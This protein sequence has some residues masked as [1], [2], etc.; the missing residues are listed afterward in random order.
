MRT[1]G[2]DILMDIDLLVAEEQQEA[3]IEILVRNGWAADKLDRF[4]GFRHH[5]PPLR[6]PSSV[7][8]EIHHGLGTG[9]CERVLPAREAIE[10]S[11]AAELDGL[12]VRV[13]APQDLL[14][15]LIM[16]S[17][18]QH[19][20]DQRIWPPVRAMADLLFLDR[21]FG[22]DLRWDSVAD[23]FRAAGRY[24][25]FALHLLQ[26]RD[27]LGLALPPRVR[28]NPFLRLCR[29]H[30]KTL[31]RHPKLRYFDPFYMLPMALAHR[32]RRLCKIL[33]TRNG[34]RYMLS[35]IL[36]PENYA[37]L[38]GDLVKGGRTF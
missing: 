1:L 27:C 22:P 20:H 16:H 6:R 18:I 24:G 9:V 23:R 2:T 5:S 34:A 37:R 26:V 32:L 8:I 14:A 31:Q 10:M 19:M 25:V 21:R 15:H 11:G 29:Y 28:L 4:S 36:A 12:H 7:W 35:Q 3:A 33:A 17:Q 30:R 13:P 38:C